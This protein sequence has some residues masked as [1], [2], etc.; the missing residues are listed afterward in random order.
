MSAKKQLRKKLGR[1]A[2]LV[3]VLAVF[4]VTGVQVVGG[5]TAL[6]DDL[7]GLVVDWN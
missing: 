4:G 5:E 6:A 1:A 3:F 2:V 7:L